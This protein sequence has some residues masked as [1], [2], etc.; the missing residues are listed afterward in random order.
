MNCV[1]PLTAQELGFV[2]AY[3]CMGL[4][5]VALSVHLALRAWIDF[6]NRKG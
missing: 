1:Q 6:L 2:I 4:T 3:V 5:S